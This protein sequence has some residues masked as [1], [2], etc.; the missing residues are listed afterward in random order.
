MH[1]FLPTEVQGPEA[2]LSWL[3]DLLQ[4]V[5]EAARMPVGDTQ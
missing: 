2:G 4:Q 5:P 1:L 3:E